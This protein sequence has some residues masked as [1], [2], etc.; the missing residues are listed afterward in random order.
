MGI[1]IRE[2][3]SGEILVGLVPAVGNIV[4]PVWDPVNEDWIVQEI[5][6]PVAPVTP[7]LPRAN[8]AGIVGSGVIAPAADAASASVQIFSEPGSTSGLGFICVMQATVLVAAA[9]A[10]D[11]SIVL[12]YSPDNAAW[13]TVASV[14]WLAD[15]SANA[16]VQLG[17]GVGSIN[18]NTDNY[19]RM[20]GINAAGSVGNIDF[21]GGAFT[22][23]ECTLA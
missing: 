13:S 9:G 14:A 6:T 20:R 18:M 8:A 23:S 2:A 19:F 7:T 5:V 11:F 16:Q 4:V 12:E 21:L 10:Y 15:F 1:R 3:P 17:G 22:Y